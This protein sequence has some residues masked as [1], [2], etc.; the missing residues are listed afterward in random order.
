M[1][2][3]TLR[4]LGLH[5]IILQ[6]LGKNITTMNTKK[7]CWQ[8]PPKNYLKLN[9][10]GASKGNL[11]VTGFGGL[12]RN[13]KGIILLIFH[14]HLGKATNNMVKLMAMEIG[15]EILIIN[16]SSN[17]I[18]EEDSEITINSVKRIS[19]GSKSEKVSKN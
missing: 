4:L 2:L 10:S 5:K 18:I 6:G 19:Y 15:L 3:R 16:R 7:D 12:L 8:P 17:L 11:G 9:I 14:N 13:E 1:E